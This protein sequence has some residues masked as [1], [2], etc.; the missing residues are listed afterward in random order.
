VPPEGGHLWDW[1]WTISRRRRSGPE[2][3]TYAEIGEWQRVTATL[4]RPE[5][6]TVLMR[7]DD[8]FLSEVR[9]EQQAAE[10]RAREKRERRNG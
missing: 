8:A 2:A 1:F 7:M 6:I 9:A 3:I 4:V 5:E 10:E